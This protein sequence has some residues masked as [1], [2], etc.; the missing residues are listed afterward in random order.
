[1][2]ENEAGAALTAKQN[3]R[4]LMIAQL[5]S[6]PIPVFQLDDA[7]GEQSTIVQSLSAGRPL[8]SAGE[9]NLST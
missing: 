1:V 5:T 2:T 9:N 4:W 8:N 6:C 7:D 3:L